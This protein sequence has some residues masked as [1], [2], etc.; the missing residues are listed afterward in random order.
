MITSNKMIK[1]LAEAGL[2]FSD[3]TNFINNR[4]PSDKQ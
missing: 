2:S 1:K 3:L 4:I